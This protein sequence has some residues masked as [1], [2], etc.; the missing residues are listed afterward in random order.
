MTRTEAIAAI[1]KIAGASLTEE[2]VRGLEG[3][4]QEQLQFIAEG[5]EN[6]GKVRDK[7]VWPKIVEVLKQAPEWIELATKLAAA[8]AAIG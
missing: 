4:T 6:I 5:W 8:I 2:D 3:C 7:A 1:R